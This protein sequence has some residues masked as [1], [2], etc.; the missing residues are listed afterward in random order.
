[1]RKSPGKPQKSY[2][3]PIGEKVDLDIQGR[4]RGERRE[5]GGETRNPKPRTIKT[6]F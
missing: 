3:T 1:M 6:R 2:L 4:S 5:T